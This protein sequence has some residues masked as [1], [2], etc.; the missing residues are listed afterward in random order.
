M[1]SEFENKQSICSKES[2]QTRLIS[3]FNVI[4]AAFYQLPRGFSGNLTHTNHGYAEHSRA[5]H[6]CALGGTLGV[7]GEL[8]TLFPLGD[9]KHFFHINF[10]AGQPGFHV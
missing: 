7:T 6:G 3:G 5:C 9:W 10:S 8:T 2:I 1:T 4:K